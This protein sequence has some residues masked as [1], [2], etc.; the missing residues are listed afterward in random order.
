MKQLKNIKTRTAM[1]FIGLFVMTTGRKAFEIKRKRNDSFK[2][3]GKK[4]ISGEC[5]KNIAFMWLIQCENT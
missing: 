3:R 2:R 4:K 5:Q 1:Y